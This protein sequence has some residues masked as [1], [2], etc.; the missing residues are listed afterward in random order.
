M[1]FKRWLG[2]WRPVLGFDTETGGLEWWRDELRL[3]QFGDASSGWV[4]PF[5]EW[6]G[7]V[8][9]SFSEYEG[10]LVAHNA[11]FD[12]HF[13]ERERIY[14]RRDRLHDTSVMAHI[15][16][17]TRSRG[18]KNL[19]VTLIDPN[20]N[21]GQRALVEGM[22]RQKWTWATVPENFTP[23]WAYAA[24]DPVITARLY[25]LFR[26]Q[27]Q[28]EFA[29]VYDLEMGTAFVIC[30]METRGVPIDLE[31][32]RGMSATLWLE[33]TALAEFIHQEYGLRP[34]SND[35]IAAQFL[36]DGI[37]LIKRTDKGKWSV[38]EE[39]LSSLSEIHPLADMVLRY[40]QATKFRSTYFE[41]ILALH[42][43][44]RLHAS[45][46]PLG[47]RTARMSVSRPPL[48]QLPSKSP[49]VRD[50]ILAPDGHT[51]GMIDFDQIEVRLLAHFAQEPEMIREICGG[52]DLHWFAARKMY[53]P[54]ATPA[55]RKRSKSGTFGKIFGIGVEKFAVQQKVSLAEAQA[56]LAM[57]DSTFPQVPAFIQDVIR[58][59]RQRKYDDGFGWVRTP[60]GRMHRLQPNDNGYYKLVN[61]LIQGTA[62]DVLKKKLVELDAAG[63]GPYM[64]LPVHDEIIFQLP[65]ADAREIMAEAREVMQD[66]HSF[67]VP[68][69]AG[70]D[71]YPR[72]GDKYR[73]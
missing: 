12:L 36:R 25:E 44:G 23:Y 13:L 72:W 24:L 52:E 38:D 54:D 51:L 34:G 60:L 40:R 32:T 14:P 7:L 68:L 16:D 61:Y 59:G 73:D 39:V 10:D 57:Y 55:D 58:I 11:V 47:A 67:A 30:D 6:R 2:H 53:G 71:I 3:V 46:D 26:T 28:S 17:S 5:R 48:Q 50:C 21:I 37:P 49:L 66:L 69:T 27:I 70:T 9:E 15:L 64:L 20:A 45:I 4:I 41:K 8:A 22:A 65:L 63:F 33:A 1:E 29:P 56:F 19:G 62:A 42:D 18:L 35:A 43:S 31:Y